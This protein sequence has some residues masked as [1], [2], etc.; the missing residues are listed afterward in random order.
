MFH[1]VIIKT[2]TV[3]LFR[4]EVVISITWYDNSFYIM[5]TGI[6]YCIL[7]IYCAIVQGGSI[8]H[9]FELVLLLKGQCHDIFE[10]RFFSQTIPAR[11]MIHGKRPFRIWLRIRRDIR[12]GSCVSRLPR[13]H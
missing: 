6:V 9:I 2:L 5:I 13:S 1:C 8:L 3:F 4:L 12:F 11:A 7:P 10:P